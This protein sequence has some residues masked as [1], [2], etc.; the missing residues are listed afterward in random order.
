[1]AIDFGRRWEAESAAWRTRT[2]SHRRC[3]FGSVSKTYCC[4][5]TAEMEPSIRICR[6][7]FDTNS[8]G[9]SRA[10]VSPRLPGIFSAQR[11]PRPTLKLIA[12]SV[13]QS[14][15]AACGPSTDCSA[16]CS[17]P[18]DSA[19]W[20]SWTS[21][22]NLTANLNLPLASFF[23]RPAPASSAKRNGRPQSGNG[24]AC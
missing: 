3:S 12:A 15:Q 1:M 17:P 2:T 6:A 10:S 24:R 18:V 14:G 9:L 22:T 11:F 7:D 21:G 20:R 5:S 4:C 13:H 19:W 8:L 16:P 23:S